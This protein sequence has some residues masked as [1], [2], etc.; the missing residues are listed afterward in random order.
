VE[1]SFN[2]SAYSSVGAAGIW[3]FMRRTGK[4]HLRINNL[5]DERRD[6][7]Q[8]TRAAAEYLAHAYSVLGSWPLAVTSYNHGITG[9]LRGAKAARSRELATIISRYDGSTWGFASQNFY[10]E[11]LA[12]LEVERNYELYFPG[13]VREEP[14]FFDE[15]EVIRPVAFRTLASAAGMDA[16][17][18]SDLN[19]ALLSPVT[20]GRFPIPAGTV[21]KVPRGYGKR[22]VE[23]VGSLRLFAPASPRAALRPIDLPEERSSGRRVYSKQVSTPSAPPKKTHR[24]SPGETAG[25]IARRYSVTPEA[26][27]RENGIRD[28]RKLKAGQKLRIP[29]SPSRKVSSSGRK[30]TGKKLKKR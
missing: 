23:K 5:V 10:C 6:P 18:F 17:S 15:M 22:V 3:Q 25:S 9:V 2:Y 7:I 27:M 13:L 11:F 12:A 16:A 8:S 14:R 29:A 30:V 21:I 19:P 20:K 24:V 28:A 26:L 1:S 4:K